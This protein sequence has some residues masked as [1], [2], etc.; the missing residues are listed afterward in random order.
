[1]FPPYRRLC[2]SPFQ[3]AGYTTHVPLNKPPSSASSKPLLRQP[4][5]PDHLMLIKENVLSSTT[6]SSSSGSKRLCSAPTNH[7]PAHTRTHTRW[8]HDKRFWS[9]RTPKRRW[10]DKTVQQEQLL[11]NRSGGHSCL[12]FAM[13][14]SSLGRR[15]DAHNER[16]TCIQIR[17]VPFCLRADTAMTETMPPAITSTLQ[18]DRNY[19][20]NNK[21]AAQP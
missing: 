13:P 21:G 20:K 18:R 2:H 9:R 10:E 7:N 5:S 19:N 4:F 15:E 3:R 11:L 12:E 8:P 17:Y 1:M 6:A 14:S 16:C